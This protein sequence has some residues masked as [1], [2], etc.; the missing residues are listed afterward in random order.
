MRKEIFNIS[1]EEVWTIEKIQQI[2]VKKTKNARFVEN[3]VTS[4]QDDG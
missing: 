3:F 4:K 2:G 1:T